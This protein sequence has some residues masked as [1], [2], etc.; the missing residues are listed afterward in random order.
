RVNKCSG[1]R[2]P[3][4]QIT[5]CP[6]RLIQSQSNSN[7]SS[8]QSSSS[9]SHMSTS[10]KTSSKS[11]TVL[12]EENS[13]TE[14]KINVAFNDSSSESN[15]GTE[16]EDDRELCPFCND[17]LPDNP[18]SKLIEM[19][20]SLLKILKKR[21]GAMSLDFSQTA[22]F[23]QLHHDECTTIPLGV[24]EGWPTVINFE[25]LETFV[26]SILSENRLYQ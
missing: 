7:K 25:G 5:T 3:N 22:D 10:K 11:V 6:H 14:S 1:C 2:S 19:K 16:P 20:D 23:C 13:E 24:A 9:K 12:E 15:S 8:I 4:H 17:P 21:R 18:S 26:I